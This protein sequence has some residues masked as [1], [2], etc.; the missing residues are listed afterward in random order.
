ML[1][2]SLA[3][4]SFGLVFVGF[5][6]A[7]FPMH[8]LGLRGMPRRVYTYLPEQNWGG[9]NMLATLGAVVL[10][11][12][13]LAFMVNVL[14]SRRFG[15]VPGDNPWGAGT[16]EWAAASPPQPYSFEYPPTVRGR[17]P[18]WEDPA[19]T[20]VVTG[21]ATDTREVLVTTPH[22]AEPHHRHHMP[23]DSIW[24]FLAALVVGATFVGLVFTPWAFVAGFV[25]L[26]VTLMGWFWPSHEPEGIHHPHTRPAVAGEGPP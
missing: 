10:A 2:E 1:S 22:D 23:D 25:G 12:G 4:V 8:Y 19:S 18:L 11:L 24:P 15:R 26:L 7:F 13:I 21:L 20:P 9:M 3:A 17:E 5:N 6:A 14:W 16:L